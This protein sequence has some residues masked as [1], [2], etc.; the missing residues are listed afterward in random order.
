MEAEGVMEAVALQARNFS[1]LQLRLQLFDDYAHRDPVAWKR[2]W[3]EFLRLGNLLQFLGQFEF[4]TSLGLADAMYER[5]FEFE[6]TPAGGS[7]DHQVGSLLELVAPE[8]RDLCRT[9]AEAGKKLPE[10]GFELTSSEGEII[11]T[12]ELTWPDPQI[13]LLLAQEAEGAARFEAL[14]WQV[15]LADDVL[16][17]PA[18]LI[19]LL[20]AGRVP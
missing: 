8:L 16:A 19:D 4:V 2:A 15:F 20:P 17:A 9:L 7:P 12:A 11:A 18:N 6:A 3:R 1:G 10:A 5:V 13:A 14:G